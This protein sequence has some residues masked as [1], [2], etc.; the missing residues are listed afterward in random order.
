MKLS[1]LDYEQKLVYMYF[2][3]DAKFISELFLSN[4]R[5]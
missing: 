2:V 1:L 5:I 4:W 3:L